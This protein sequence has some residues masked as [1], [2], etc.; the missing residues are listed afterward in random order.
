M[1]YED[2][3][4]HMPKG[5]PQQKTKDEGKCCPDK[6]QSGKNPIKHPQKDL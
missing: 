6:C 2:K 1:S 3:N 5:N 4:K